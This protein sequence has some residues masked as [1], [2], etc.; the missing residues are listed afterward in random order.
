MEPKLKTK[1]VPSILRA[2]VDRL[3][4]RHQDIVGLLGQLIVQKQQQKSSNAV[5]SL[6]QSLKNKISG[7]EY[8]Y[9][10]IIPLMKQHD[11]LRNQLESLEKQRTS[12][13]EHQ[14]SQIL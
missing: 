2:D 4:S 6:S 10:K 1:S 7:K 12:L 8:G 11:V 9:S 5:S 13:Q 3:Y 14:T